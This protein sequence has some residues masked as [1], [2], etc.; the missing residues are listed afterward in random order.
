MT[1]RTD[2]SFR[3]L[4]LL[5]WWAAA[6]GVAAVAVSIVTTT[7]WLLSIARQNSSLRF[8]AIKIGLSVGAGIGAG[9]ALVLS[10]RRQWLSERSQAHTENVA[11]G[12][13]YD[14]EQRRITELYGRA[15]EQL[16]HERA[17][18]RLGGL[19]SLERLA[20]DEPGH[21]QTV[22]GVVCAYLRMP[23]ELAPEIPDPQPDNKTEP[24]S[25]NTYLDKI[26]GHSSVSA[27]AES[28]KEFQVRMTA[29]RLLARHLMIEPPDTNP[30]R[31]GELPDTYWQ[32]ITI[33][34]SGALL[35]NLDFSKCRIRSID[36]R[37][38]SFR[39]HT[40]FQDAQLDSKI[41]FL[42]AE[43]D[44]EAWF[45]GTQFNAH[46][47]FHGVHFGGNAWFQGAQFRATA[48]FRRARFSSVA[49]FGDA[50]FTKD[51][52]F[53]GAQFNEDGGFRG[54]RFSR[55][56]GFRGVQFFKAA[57]FRGTHFNGDARFDLARFG[58]DARFN[59]SEF[60]AAATFKG[61]EFQKNAAFQ[62]AQFI[63]DAQF[64]GTRFCNPVKFGHAH[65]KV[66]GEHVWPD[67]WRLE[68]TPPEALTGRIIYD[69]KS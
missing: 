36:F 10:F 34:L 41:S 26:F 13:A 68:Q 5:P 3:P 45:K 4:K 37:G 42:G 50:E 65:A 59:N 6:L 16:G 7:L 12:S 33:D 63:G 51:V 57:V 69:S 31:P 1:D 44:G 21:R 52:S 43:F 9:F 67:G 40:N 58:G 11:R 39:G 20:Q 25:E 19:Y 62:G 8:E 23:F 28:L 14:A 60:H 53:D 27:D 61:V 56:S 24:D 38:A 30:R 66:T 35:I 55:S 29:Q 32:E 54:A 15:V 48:S 64:D 2:N 49:G 18:V 22:I 47:G 46:A 17:A